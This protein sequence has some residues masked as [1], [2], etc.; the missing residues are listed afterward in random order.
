MYFESHPLTF[1]PYLRKVSNASECLQQT[2]FM[3]SSS[4]IPFSSDIQSP[5]VAKAAPCFCNFQSYVPL[6]TAHVSSSIGLQMNK[7]SYIIL[8][9][10]R[11][12]QMNM[13]LS[14]FPNTVKVVLP[15]RILNRLMR[16]ISVLSMHQLVDQIT[17]LY[18]LKRNA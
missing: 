12:K 5:D 3:D 17:V 10:D 9:A 6:E 1:R 7:L 11:L 13:E 14:R 2:S 8:L 15:P 4:C 16:Q 18:V